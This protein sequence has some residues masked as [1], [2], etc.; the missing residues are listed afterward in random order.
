MEVSSDPYLPYD[1]GGDSIPLREL[2]KRG[3]T[4]ACCDSVFVSVCMCMCVGVGVGGRLL[5]LQ[6][7]V[8]NCFLNA[9]V[10]H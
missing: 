8:L 5:L 3:I 2:H 4:N 7:G 6:K 1:G 10:F 9:A